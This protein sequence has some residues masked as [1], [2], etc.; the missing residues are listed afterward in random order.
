MA[1]KKPF[2]V[3][4]IVIEQDSNRRVGDTFGI[5]YSWA[6]ANKLCMKLHQSAPQN[7]YAIRELMHGNHWLKG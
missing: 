5:F 7:F 1:Q 4:Y 6:Q 2:K 3:R